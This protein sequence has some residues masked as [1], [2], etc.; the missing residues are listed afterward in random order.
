MV[1]V[2]REA[3]HSW[4]MMAAR[5][6]R[7]IQIRR[8]GGRLGQCCPRGR[9]ELVNDGRPGRPNLSNLGGGGSTWSMLPAGPARVGQW[10]PPDSAELVS[11]W[12]AGGPTWTIR[13]ATCSSVATSYYSS[14]P[15][16]TYDALCPRKLAQAALPP[17]PLANRRTRPRTD[18]R[19]PS[20]GLMS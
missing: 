2:A 13:S 17:R 19:G 5:V 16:S 20:I 11:L 9:A 18:G 6:G 14:V 3:G 8:A 4:S 10:W 15:S 1:N 7:I 12:G